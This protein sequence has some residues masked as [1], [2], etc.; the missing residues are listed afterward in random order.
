MDTQS[1]WRCLKKTNSVSSLISAFVVCFSLVVI[2]S[3]SRLGVSKTTNW[4]SSI[5]FTNLANAGRFYAT[6]HR[7]HAKILRCQRCSVQR[8]RQFQYQPWPVKIIW[9]D[10]RDFVFTVC[11]SERFLA[12]IFLRKRTNVVAQVLWPYWISCS[13]HGKKAVTKTNRTMFGKCHSFHRLLTFNCVFICFFA[14]NLYKLK[15]P[16]SV[17]WFFICVHCRFFH[18]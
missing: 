14:H 17:M 16:F 7:W 8:N 10:A 11:S 2:N 12:S 13:L 4:L 9:L 15:N 6:V 18:G 1:R 5:V 3:R